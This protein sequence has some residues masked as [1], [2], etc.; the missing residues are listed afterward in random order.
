MNDRLNASANNRPLTDKTCGRADDLVAYLYNE[1]SPSGARSFTE[2]L[3][4]CAA[5]R[6]ELA[7]FSGVRENVAVWR[8]E[9]L[10]AAPRIDFTPD[11]FGLHQPQPRK[12]SALLALREFFSLSP[13]WLRAATATAALVIFA[14]VALTFART[15]VR[16]DKDGF[17]LE[18]GIEEKKVE[19][20]SPATLTQ[21]QA[22]EIAAQRVK[23]ALAEQE[24]TF[25]KREEELMRAAAQTQEERERPINVVVNDSRPIRRNP[26]PGKIKRGGAQNNL[27]YEQENN[28]D[29]P[30]LY[31]LLREAN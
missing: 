1:A 20:P 18:M 23:A 8:A 25:A 28:D 29:A 6:D 9:V 2:H 31:D 24:R 10:D 3:N 14:L 17:A 30:G 12:R 4:A 13:L 21:Q 11:S 7:A 27:V 26:S 15:D 16:W 5:C 22:D 19:V